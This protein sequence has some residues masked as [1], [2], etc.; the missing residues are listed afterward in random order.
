MPNLTEVAEHITTIV[1][2]RGTI[3]GAK[4]GGELSRSYPELRY[5]PGY[6]DMGLRR[7]I[8]EYCR[9]KV[10]IIG[11]HGLD[12]IY[13]PV[14]ESAAAPLLVVAEPAVT[15]Q[16]PTNEK[17]VLVRKRLTLWDVFQRPGVDDQLIVNV[18]SGELRLVKDREQ[19]PAGFALL[20]SVSREEHLGIARD[21]LPSIGEG[22][23]TQF[24]KALQEED[25]WSHWLRAMTVASRYKQEWVKYRFSRL[26]DIF[27]ARLG[28]HGVNEKAIA[29]CIEQL[30]QAKTME[31]L[32]RRMPAGV[33]RDDYVKM[34]SEGVSDPHVRAVVEKVVN[35]MSDRD[36]QRLWLPLG[37]VLDA[38]RTS[39]R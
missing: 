1:R 4:L 5:Q 11:K 26:C 21:F 8:E 36:L 28:G 15:E 16:S 27:R 7:F 18:E 25:Y 14:G 34:P 39:R 9:G 10:K 38:L 22:D 30:L 12:D 24:E 31:R 6:V 2:A 20:E 13:G 3:L 35:S 37:D 32:V 33:R 29:K 17:P 19:L 23:R